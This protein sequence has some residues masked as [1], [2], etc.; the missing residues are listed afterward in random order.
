[1]LYVSRGGK[2]LSWCLK[3]TPKA[4]AWFELSRKQEICFPLSPSLSLAPPR[5]FL[6]NFNET[7]FSKRKSSFNFA[8]KI[9]FPF[10]F[11]GNFHLRRRNE[12]K[13][14]ITLNLYTPT[15]MYTCG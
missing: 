13:K 1:M 12:N 10:K 3:L 4:G 7:W 6:F 8:P 5:P 2:M 9:N 14:S 15:H 11:R